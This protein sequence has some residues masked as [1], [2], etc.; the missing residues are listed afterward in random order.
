MAFLQLWQY[1]KKQRKEKSA[2]QFRKLCKREFL[3]WT[4]VN[5]WFDLNRQFYQQAREEKL[6]FNKKAATPEQVHQALLAGLLSHVGNKNPE[7][8]GYMGP[9]SR[10]FHIFPGSGLFGRR[11]QWLMAAEI[12]ETSKT[13]S[14]TN[15]VIKPEWIE[16]AATHLL[17]HHY[18]DPH[19]SR[20]QG[21]V[22]AWEQVALFGLVIVEKRRV[23]YSRINP[24]EARQIFISG[25]LVRGELDTR[26]GFLQNNQQ[27]REE[28]EELEHKRRKHD[29]MADESVL[30][31]FFDARIPEDVCDSISFEKWL[32]QLGKTGRQQ[33]YIG[34]DVLMQ[35]QA[36][37]A[38]GDLYPDSI[39]IGVQ[40]LPLSYQF[41]PGDVA[42]GVTLVVPL[43]RL[44]TLVDGQL[45]WLVPGLLRDKIIA[46]IKNLPKPQRRALTPVPQFA[47]AALERLGDKSPAPLLPALAAALKAMTGIEIEAD[48]FDESLLP[49]YLRFRVE[50][51]DENEQCIAV[52]R[53][54]TEL[55]QQFGQQAKHHFMER[56]G[57]E[58]QR[59]NETDWVF[60]DLP[61]S[62]LTKD[63][64]GQSTEAWPAVVDQDD[65]VGLRMF[66][67]AEEAALEHH[68]GVLRLL[69]LQLGSKLRDLRKHHGLSATALIAW[70]AAGSPE[71]L[72]DGL[73]ESS[74]AL[75]AGNRPVGIR[76]EAAFRTL[77]ESVRSELGLVFRKQS[78]H[79]DKALK[80]W[81]EITNV[82]DDA[83]YHHRP[84]VYND[85]RT[86]L[87]DMLYDGFMHE[88][89]PAR[90]E[91]YSRYLEAMSIRL[92]SV[93]K[94]PHRDAVRMKEIGPFWQ[95]YLQLLEDGRDYDENVDEYR[96]LME[97]FRVSLFAQQLGTRTKVS[98]QRLQKAWKQIG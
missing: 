12:V 74:M 34:H 40:N 89:P 47:D 18:F 84:D 21:R 61:G 57:T 77:L 33:L 46:L 88:L 16:A 94:D 70:S 98:V 6:S 64:S 28:I 10:T 22:L 38:P 17:K 2:S 26:A 3:N 41:K 14:R 35:E 31:E 55:Q 69:A 52:G 68:H 51:I 45:Q 78:G 79:L 73:V 93:E 25:A 24:Q 86:Q 9:R 4:R 44:N 65:A 43:E 8:N 58:H 72:I 27:V 62:E 48:A 32:K 30:F 20:K 53:N 15:A 83:Y 11:P 80:R 50:V 91:H 42:D 63:G 96:W 90:L 92:T 23:N 95:Q 49:D 82:L 60:G 87:D 39:K 36:G 5:E 19:W 76:D 75:V 37:D 59:D 81:S 1:L 97:E 66:D 7:D 56:L 54:L 29:V 85:M 71:T 67:T 13:Y